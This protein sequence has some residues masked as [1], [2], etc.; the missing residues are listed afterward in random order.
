MVELVELVF[1]TGFL[2]LKN[3]IVTYVF[4]QTLNHGQDATEGQFLSRVKMV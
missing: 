4:F 1:K 2:K 3:Q